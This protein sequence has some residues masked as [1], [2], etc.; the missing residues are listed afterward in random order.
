MAGTVT[1]I[2]DKIMRLMRSM[3]YFALRVQP[4]QELSAIELSH[5]INRTGVAGSVHHGVVEFALQ[6]LLSEGRVRRQGARWCLQG[7][8][9]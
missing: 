2:S 3:V 1:V 4:G 6:E 8:A 7:A 5:Y 9:S